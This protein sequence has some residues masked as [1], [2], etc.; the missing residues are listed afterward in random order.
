MR[1]RSYI[2]NRIHRVTRQNQEKEVWTVKKEVRHALMEQHNGGLIV[3]SLAQVKRSEVR[4]TESKVEYILL[5]NHRHLVVSNALKTG[6][7]GL[8]D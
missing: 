7:F 6:H 1:Y 2:Q 8:E 5:G 3:R 4:E